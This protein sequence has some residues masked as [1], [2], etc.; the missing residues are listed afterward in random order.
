MMEMVPKEEP[1]SSKEFHVDSSSRRL[2]RYAAERNKKFILDVLKGQ[3]EKRHMES[4]SKIKLLEVA[5][6]TGEHAALFME[7]I[8]NLWYQP[9]EMDS[10]MH[11]SIGAWL[12]PFSHNAQFPIKLDV[13]YFLDD[14]QQIDSTFF[15]S[16]QCVDIVVCINMIHISPWSSTVHLFEMANKILQPQGFLLTYGPYR[17]NGHMVES[18]VRFDESL[19]AKNAEWGVRDIEEVEK[20]AQRAGLVILETIQ[21][22]ANNLCIVF[23]RSSM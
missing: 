5:S 16:D 22:P 6:G 3:M 12:E 4:V 14:L 2:A 17:V 8:P 20:A 7:H 21:M 15:P 18:N 13:N 19:K 10:T 1:S 11:D 23:G 9:T